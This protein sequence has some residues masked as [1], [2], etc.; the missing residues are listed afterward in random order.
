MSRRYRTNFGRIRELGELDDEPPEGYNTG[1][2][3]S[4][5]GSLLVWV[6]I[7]SLVALIV[8]R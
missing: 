2:C 6:V 1:C 8:L 4:I 7:L 5:L 3:L